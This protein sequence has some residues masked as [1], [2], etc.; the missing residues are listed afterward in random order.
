[1]QLKQLDIRAWLCCFS[2]ICWL[3]SG[4]FCPFS[5]Q[6]QQPLNARER[7]SFWVTKGQNLMRAS[8]YAEAYT[9]FQLARSLGAPNMAA[10]M[11][12]AKKRNI[13]SIQ[14]R[15]L[16][17]EARARATTDPTQSLRLLEYAHQKF[18]DSLS[19][20]KLIGEVANMPDNWYY[21]LRARYI[22]VSPKFTYVLAETDKNRL[23]R[24]QGDSLRLVHTF[25]EQFIFSTL[26][27]DDRFLLVASLSQARV[28]ALQ[29]GQ[30]R[31]VRTINEPLITARFSPSS[32]PAYGFWV[33]TLTTDRI[34]TL[35]S[36]QSSASYQ[37]TDADTV[38]TERCSFSPGGRYLLTPAGV[39]QLMPNKIRAVPLTGDDGWGEIATH[40]SRFSGDNQRLLITKNEDLSKTSASRQLA[41]YRFSE[42]G[43]SLHYVSNFQARMDLPRK[44]WR[45]FSSNSRYLTYTDSL[46]YIN[47]TQ[48]EL[49]RSVTKP[50]QS[51]PLESNL[52]EGHE[53]GA[54]FRFSPTNTHVLREVR[55]ANL[56]PVFQLW[57]LE[58]AQR[59]FVHTFTDKVSVAEDVFSPDGK[60]LLSRHTTSDLLY[61]LEADTM[62]LVHRFS[63]PLRKPAQG[64]FDDDG[65]PMASLYFSPNSR[66]LLS[67]GASLKT[68]DS[69][70]QLP[71]NVAGVLLPVYGFRNRLQEAFTVF[72]PDEHFLLTVERGSQLA[73]VWSLSEQ[74]ALQSNRMMPPAQALFSSK[75]NYLLTNAPG[76]DSLGVDAFAVG[77]PSQ[78]WRVSDRQLQPL[79]QLPPAG[80]LANYQFSTDEQFLSQ[81]GQ[82][83]VGDSVINQTTLYSLRANRTIPIKRYWTAPFQ[84]GLDGDYLAYIHTYQSGVFSTDGRHWLQSQ[85]V[86]SPDYAKASLPPDTL[87]SLHQAQ[88]SIALQP[89]NR[90][91]RYTIKN[92]YAFNRKDFP[93]STSF[94]N[95]YSV[96]SALFSRNGQFML[97]NERDSLRFYQLKPTPV[98]IGSLAGQRG[99]PMDVSASGEYWL[100][101]VPA[102]YAWPT[103][104][105]QQRY[106]TVGDIA[107]RDTPDTVRLWRQTGPD[108]KPNWKSI[109]IIGGLYPGLNLTWQGNQRQSLFSKTGNYLLL[110]TT[111]PIM[112][113][114][115]NIVGDNLLPVLKLNTILSTAAYLPPSPQ[116][117]WDVGLLYTDFDQQT[118]LFR[119]GTAGS[120][121]T[122][123]GNGKLEYPPRFWGQ[124]AYWVRK[125]DDSQQQVELL[126]MPSGQTL[127]QVPF[128]SVLDFTV[129]PN[130]DT[131]VVSIEGARLI[132][133][134]LST[135]R[136]LKQSSIAPL[137]PSLRQLYTFL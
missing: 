14:F 49:V 7:A 66:Y 21:S 3:L 64:I 105:Q 46:F 88:L 125:I 4:L 13:N 11:E 28:Y 12:L 22:Q 42:Q 83:N 24:R 91:D 114:L 119:Y 113:T 36:L 48:K 115:F 41:Q 82:G 74:V 121:I 30:I 2:T 34:T 53:F 1:M 108:Y 96:P 59:F 9:A 75:G 17:G 85:V 45:P 61:R 43:D 57:R 84:Y 65:Y 79:D 44:L 58:G 120:R 23:Y 62:V 89:A 52:N 25:N 92:A 106:L 86:S 40:Y 5:I 27:P 8:Q 10:Q 116:K 93:S 70:W 135:L 73:T 124:Q 76:V 122:S 32:N 80:S 78:L 38:Q 60:Y 136:W 72:S 118:Y 18:P 99:F 101:G 109:A 15:A 19:V 81:S 126:D 90:I 132:R 67:Y 20:L 127:V 33:M 56:N 26:S 111:E 31:L 110:P 104:P 95:W 133:S 47:G 130:G 123:L 102:A 134:P 35:Y 39:W 137:Q 77:S 129:R 55:D 98:A 94:Q 37:L 29:N 54:D 103:G 112:T 128:G 87:W 100:T 97:T 107:Q 50:G 51:Q 131:W 16:T 63:K 68:A 117:G 69:L 6:A 71:D